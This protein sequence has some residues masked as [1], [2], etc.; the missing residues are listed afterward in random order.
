MINR[1][2]AVHTKE[3]AMGNNTS[4]RRTSKP[5]LAIKFSKGNLVSN[6]L[7][8]CIAAIAPKNQTVGTPKHTRKNNAVHAPVRPLLVFFEKSF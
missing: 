5:R 7:V 1:Q 3:N 6:R 8:N 4:V 2:M